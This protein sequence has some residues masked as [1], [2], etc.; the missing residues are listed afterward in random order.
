MDPTG[1]TLSA[2]AEDLAT[3]RT[4]S[5]ALVEA[6]LGEIARDDRAFRAVDAAGARAAA[7]ACDTLRGLGLAPTPFAGAP[8]S[9]KDLFD[10]AGTLTGGGN[11]DWR[12]DQEPA[13]AHAPAVAALLAAGADLW[14]KTVTDEL[15][16]SLAGANFHYGT[17][18]NTAAPGHVPGGSSSGSASAVAG[19]V[20]D[21]ALGTD[22]LQGELSRVV[23]PHAWPA[24][25]A[26]GRRHARGHG[27]QRPRSAHN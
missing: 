2:I 11:P 16:F 18:D 3:G 20:V 26:R 19:R 24:F 15:A 1:R 27:H 5:R 7:D 8:V 14:G 6:A 13:V 23:E 25:K 12:S 9:V 10:V 21:L 17:P 22:L 4:T